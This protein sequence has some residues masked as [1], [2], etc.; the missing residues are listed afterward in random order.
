MATDEQVAALKSKTA[1]ASTGLSDE[2]LDD[3]IDENDG[4][5]DLTAAQIWEEYASATAALVDVSESGSS[6]SLGAIHKNALGMATHYRS[7]SIAA[8]IP[9]LGARARTRAIQRP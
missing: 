6:R 9:A 1:G 8:V 2:I 5:V 4:D 7:R 3:R